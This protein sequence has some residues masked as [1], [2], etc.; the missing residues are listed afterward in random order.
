MHMALQ[1]GVLMS[2]PGFPLRGDPL[3]ILSVAQEWGGGGAPGAGA[4]PYFWW[5]P[6]IYG[7][8]NYFYQEVHSMFF[9]TN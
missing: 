6:L 3:L 5:S 9:A 7:P 1:R 8:K 2:G 4:P